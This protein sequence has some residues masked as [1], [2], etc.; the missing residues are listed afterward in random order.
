MVFDLSETVST[1]LT[2]L[3]DQFLTSIWG[4][5]AKK[6][7]SKKTACC[8]T[9]KMPIFV[10]HFF[11]ANF[12]DN[13]IVLNTNKFQ[14]FFTISFIFRLLFSQISSQTRK[15]DFAKQKLSLEKSLT[16]LTLLKS[17]IHFSAYV[18]NTVKHGSYNHGLYQG[19]GLIAGP[20]LIYPFKG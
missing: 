3:L 16:F 19:P 5:V 4:D 11:V 20:G 8:M 9:K 18:R 17:D 14:F 12:P 6:T 1:I 7:L 15:S 2:Q 10:L 13:I